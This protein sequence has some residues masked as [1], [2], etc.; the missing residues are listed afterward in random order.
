MISLE[1]GK[2][3]AQAGREWG[4]SIDQFRWYAEEARRIY[5][6]IIESRVPG[7]RFEVH[8]DPV[9]VVARLYRVEFPSSLDRAQ[10]GPGPCGGLFDHCPSVV[11]DA[12]AWRW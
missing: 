1:T 3:I 8:H 12:G 9:G 11:A 10:G 2:P 4:L 6:R 5:G 7:G